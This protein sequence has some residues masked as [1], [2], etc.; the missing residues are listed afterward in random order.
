V[1]EV[2][3]VVYLIPFRRRRFTKTLEAG[4]VGGGAR[5]RWAPAAENPRP[6][7]H[8]KPAA[9]LTA[10]RLKRLSLARDDAICLRAWR[11][12]LRA[13]RTAG[14]LARGLAAQAAPTGTC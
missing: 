2:S 9:M 14:G 13:A 12:L 7:L 10:R 5:G 1:V 8:A 6:R 11:S 4:P 3:Y